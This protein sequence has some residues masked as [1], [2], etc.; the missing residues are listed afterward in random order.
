M[1]PTSFVNRRPLLVLLTISV[2][3]ALVSWDYQHSPGY[4]QQTGFD[5]VPKKAADRERK[6]R[7]LDDVIDELN[8]VELKFDAEKIKAEIADAMKNFDGDKLKSQLEKAMKQ[9]D[10]AK[11][12]AEVEATLANIDYQKIKNQVA[13]AMKQIDVEKIQQ[14][15]EASL[16]KVDY[17]KMKTEIASAMKEIDVAKIQMEVQK[18]IAEMNETD[19]KKLKVEL[20]KIGPEAAQSLTKVKVEIE[21]AKAEMKEYKA[22]VKGLANDG[23]INKKEGY[24]LKLKDGKLEIN[25]KKAPDEVYSKY[26]NFLEKHT[27]FTIKKDNE[28][29]N[30]YRN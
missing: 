27:S 5:T 22:F 17:D 25:G 28:D 30:I 8:K 4:F 26:R 1:K 3:V 9:V 7:D 10:M 20:E 15:V 23:L 13:N 11:T 24:E 2:S 18:A 16:T 12:Q 21:K 6:I 14:E 29:F 19:L